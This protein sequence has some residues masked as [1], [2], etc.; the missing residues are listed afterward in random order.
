MRKRNR[1][2]SF[3]GKPASENLIQDILS[4]DGFWEL[5]LLLLSSALR[6][7]SR[8]VLR[9]QPPKDFFIA[10]RLWLF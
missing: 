3:K 2:V 6:S 4:R 10:V 9:A 5:L 8:W 1:D 7:S